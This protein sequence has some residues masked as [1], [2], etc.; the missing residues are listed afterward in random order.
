[1]IESSGRL[2]AEQGEGGGKF[3]AFISQKPIIATSQDENFVA[4]NEST[5]TVSE[6]G[7]RTT[8]AS[9]VNLN[10]EG[11]DQQGQQQQQQ[12]DG[13]SSQEALKVSQHLSS[14]LKT[15]V[16]MLIARKKGE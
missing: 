12:L 16:H 5:G 1:M 15:L 8:S 10:G 13:E 4:G 14:K 2:Q 7:T 11:G 9:V 6:S 3:R